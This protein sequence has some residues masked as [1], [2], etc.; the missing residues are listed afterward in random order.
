MLGTPA[1]MAPERVGAP[2]GV[3]A[4]ADIYG[5]GA[6]LFFLVAGRPPF[7]GSD[8][9]SLLRQVLAEPAPPL[10]SL[11][12]GV[13]EPLEALVARCLAKSPPERPGA[14]GDIAAVLEGLHLP[15]WSRADARNWWEL[16]R[17]S[18]RAADDKPPV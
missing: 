8:E 3:D 1:Y 13:P 6:L 7:E 2:S 12:H 9:A 10:G 5:V 14:V 16:W 11:A 4:R 17:E 18:T 15:Q